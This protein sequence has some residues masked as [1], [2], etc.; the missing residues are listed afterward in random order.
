M[1]VN[2]ADARRRWF[3]VFFLMVAA[4]MLIWG[5][6][7]LKPYLEGVGFVVYWVACMGFTAL[8]M[9]TA[10]LDI[11]AVR[12]RTRAQQRELLEHIF[13]ECEPDPEKKGDQ[14]EGN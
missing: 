11:W 3:G 10:L 14:S 9:F 4:G 13:E 6:T 12:R 7:L 1:P 8:A 5:Q 2:P